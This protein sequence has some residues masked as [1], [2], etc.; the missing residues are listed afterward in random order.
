M[1][2]KINHPFEPIFDK[3]SK[4]LILGSIP[5]PKSREYGF[6]YG[7]PQNRFWKILAIV[8][9]EPIPNT[10][11]E[12]KDFILRHHL[13]LWDVIESCEI[14]GASD[15]SISNVKAND[16]FNLLKKTNIKYI[17]TTGKKADSLY[18][19]YCFPET[20]IESYCFPSTSPANCACKEQKLI[21]IYEELKKWSQ[22]DE[23]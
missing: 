22:K 19:K 23:K 16:I 21:E 8:Y 15:S 9:E 10:I 2:E 11:E 1:K 3:D 20:K 18:Q 14:K 7:H 13:A 17:V 5:S 12:K 4:V 6:Y